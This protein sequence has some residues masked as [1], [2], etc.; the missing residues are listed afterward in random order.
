MRSEKTHKAKLMFRV[1]QFALWRMARSA[2]ERQRARRERGRAHEHYH[3]GG[4]MPAWVVECWINAGLLTDERSHNP[5]DV[6]A[7]IRLVCEAHAGRIKET[8]T[9]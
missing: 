7:V 6:W 8:V 4:N 2:A 3:E 1:S 5:A 9:P